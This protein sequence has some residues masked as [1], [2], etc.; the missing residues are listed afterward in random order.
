[1]I[2]RPPRSTLF[3]YT[4]LF[5]SNT[6]LTTLTETSL[7]TAATENLR[8]SQGLVAHEMAHQWFGDLVTCKDWS[9]IWLNEGFAT[10]YALLYDEHRNG[11]DSMLYG[12][13]CDARQILSMT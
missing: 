2:R 10:Y 9:H 11:R 7:F 5:R 6:S 1:M 13:Y 4:T 3:P 8:S 12:L